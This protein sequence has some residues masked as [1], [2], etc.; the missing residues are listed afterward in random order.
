M[1]GRRPGDLR[2]LT[3]LLPPTM[4]VLSVVEALSNERFDPTPVHLSVV[5]AWVPMGL[6][7]A[8][9]RPAIGVVVAAAFY[10]VGILL[11]IPGPGG[12]GLIS[13]LL[14]VGWAGFGEP[15]RRSRWALIAAMVIYAAS[16]TI[17]A[18]FSWVN[19]F[20]PLIFVVGW[21][22]GVLVQREQ[23]RSRA[24]AEMAAT[25]DAQREA[26]AH[27]A[28]MEERTRIAREIHDAVAHSVSIMTLQIGGLRSQLEDV[29]EHRPAEREVMLGLERLGRQSVEEL[30]SLVGIMRR[31][32]SE[33]PTAPTPS[34]ALAEQLIADVRAAGLPARLR[35]E[36]V[37]APLHQALDVSAYRVLQEALTNVLRHAPG[38]Q[39][40]VAIRYAA[41]TV[42]IEVRDDGAGEATDGGAGLPGSRADRPPG[43]DRTGGHGLIG[44]RE[45][46]AIFGGTLQAGPRAEGGFAVT[47]CFPIRRRWP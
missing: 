3:W 43:A 44:M 10:P 7:L 22:S 15:V 47:A 40:E 20:F 41:D 32:G 26:V 16:D 12:V 13:T 30:R 24:F 27:A 1:R 35:V 17:R 39:A 45:R 42:T 29:L 23:R 18:G 31:S 11:D 14:A 19:V 2:L 4:G 6:V 5:A 37:P 34:L 21:W 33:S 36:G 46:T 25:L 38:G 28:V 8:R 9:W